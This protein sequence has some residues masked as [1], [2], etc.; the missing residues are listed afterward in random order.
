MLV[1]LQTLIDEV[2][3]YA[4]VRQLRWP[5]G[6]RCPTYVAAEIIK[7]GFH[8]QQAHHQQ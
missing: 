8:T 2:K 5:Y 6:V 4:V 3:Y 7:C 1:N